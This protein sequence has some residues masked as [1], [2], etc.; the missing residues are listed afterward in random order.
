MFYWASRDDVETSLTSY[1]T[2]EMLPQLT[3]LRI[4]FI[5]QLWYYIIQ[6]ICKCES[7]Q[8]CPGCTK[9]ISLHQGMTIGGL[10]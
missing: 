3:V 9:R 5:E 8:I 7:W 6:H 1:K 10:T 2:C 4:H